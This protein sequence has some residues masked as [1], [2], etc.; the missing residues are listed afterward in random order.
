MAKSYATTWQNP[1]SVRADESL[2]ISTA[3]FNKNSW[4]IGFW[5]KPT[6]DQDVQSATL[7]QIY[8]DSSNYW[9]M[10]SHSNGIPFFS[11]CSGG[12]NITS[13]NASDTVMEVGT[14]YYLCAYGNSDTFGMT[15]NS[16][17]TT[18]G[19]LSYTIPVGTL[20]TYMFLGCNAAET[21]QANGIYSDFIVLP[22][23]TNENQIYGYYTL[24]RPYYA[25][26]RMEVAGDLIGEEVTAPLICDGNI[27]K[28]DIIEQPR[29]QL[30]K[31]GFELVETPGLLSVLTSA[32]EQRQEEAEAGQ[33]TY[34]VVGYCQGDPNHAGVDPNLLT[35][36]FYA[37]A[38]IYP[39]TSDVWF[40][41]AYGQYASHVTTM[42][43]LKATNPNL[44][45]ILSIGGWGCG[46]YG[47]GVGASGFEIAMS[48]AAHRANFAANC[49]AL[50][51]NY[52]LDGI[53]LDAEYPAAGDKANFTLLVQAVRDAI[54][55]SKFLGITTPAANTTTYFDLA[56]L[57]NIVDN[58]GMMAY[59]MDQTGTKHHANLYVSGLS[60]AYSCKTATDLHL[61]YVPASQLLLGV[62]FYGYVSGVG[63]KTYDQLVSNYINTG[64]YTRYYDSTA[65]APYL[66]TGG[67]FAASYDDT[68]N[69]AEKIAYIKAQNLGGIMIWQL[70]QNSDKTL[71]TAIY[72]G[73]R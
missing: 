25:L 42:V 5:F 68:V 66:K 73:F 41:P 26:P 3:I 21:N 32:Q 56:S 34:K 59:D 47:G 10:N 46:G 63:A 22:Y 53:D 19:E 37:F 2:K 24:N 29:R 72:N 8:I 20:P 13:Y 70:R 11:I 33:K 48:T 65:K 38:D 36:I 69:Q 55:D 1:S 44:N 15:I 17:L 7:F 43:G 30:Y 71:L 57:A 61:T 60:T 50:V 51:N 45:C 28:I 6:S 12:S 16:I 62:P 31:V 39:G 27:R 23:P 52:N 18:S 35:H 40:N 14:W 49:L 4:S 54:G 9:L 58:I 64:G 67:S